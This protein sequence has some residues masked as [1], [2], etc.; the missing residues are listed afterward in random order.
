LEILHTHV[1]GIDVH[2]A[3]V[4]VTARYPGRAGK[5]KQVTRTFT[6]F[7]GRLLEMARWLV[8]ECGVRAAA[9]ESTGAYLRHEGA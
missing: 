1:A 6:A 9:M 4:T 8:D 7:Y 3:Q 5:R 2:K